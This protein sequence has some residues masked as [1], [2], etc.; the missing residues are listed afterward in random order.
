MAIIRINKL[1][2]A[3]R[4]ID[5]AIRIFFGGEDPV[6]V[7]SVAAAGFRILRDLAEKNHTQVWQM[8]D[9]CI[10]PGMKKKFW[11]GEGVN[12]VANFLKHADKDSDQTLD[13]IDEIINDVTLFFACVLYQDLGYEY[14][15]EMRFFVTWY[16]CIHPDQIRDDL[17]GKAQLLEAS[18]YWRDLP[19]N[20]Q[21][22]FGKEAL[23][24]IRQQN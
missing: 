6:A 23:E 4:Q 13:N 21:L 2:A 20:Q 24:Q 19:R 16:S 1:E 14:T 17:P 5:A 9:A 18:K 8:I 10:R 22:E 3:Q 11:S 7:H 12:K 15:P